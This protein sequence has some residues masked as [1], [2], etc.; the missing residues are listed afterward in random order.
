MKH[1]VYII[2]AKKGRNQ[3][4]AISEFDSCLSIFD[5]QYAS[6]TEARKAKGTI[7]NFLKEYSIGDKVPV[8]VRA[9]KSSDASE[10][11]GQ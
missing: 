10:L 6:E 2:Q 8:R 9:L 5:K 7:K 11:P 1:P 4:V 3:W